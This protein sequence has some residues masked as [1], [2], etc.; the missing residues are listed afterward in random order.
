VNILSRLLQRLPAAVPPDKRCSFCP[1]PYVELSSRPIYDDPDG[2]PAYDV[3]RRCVDHPPPGVPEGRCETCGR[4]YW[5][6]ILHLDC[7][8]SGQECD[9]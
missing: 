8:P 2:L 4:A 5:P 7:P 6:D 9:R 1:Q 3:T